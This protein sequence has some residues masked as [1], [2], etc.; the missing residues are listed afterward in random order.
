MDIQPAFSGQPTEHCDIEQEIRFS[1][2][3]YGGVSLAIYMNGIAQEFRHLVRAT[4]PD[5][6]ASGQLKNRN[7]ESTES[8]YR[9]LGQLLSQTE[10]RPH[11]PCA[12]E[13]VRTRFV[14]DT[15]SGTSAGGIN[16]LFLAKALVND[17]KIN[18]L[19]D[20]WVDAADILDLINDAD[21]VKNTPLD[22]PKPPKAL[23]N[24]QRLY[25]QALKALNEMDESGPKPA[26][27]SP[28]VDELDVFLTTTDLRGVPTALRLSDQ[29][30]YERRH[31]N[32]FHFSYRPE[33]DD[34]DDD[35]KDTNP[36]LAFAARCT[37]SFPIAF[38]PMSLC[39]TE[40]VLKQV[41]KN[42]W[43]AYG[44]KAER[45]KR[46]YRNYE[47]PVADT[48]ADPTASQDRRKAELGF[49]PFPQ[50]FF[51]DGG[52]LDNKPFGYAI[53]TLSLRKG[54]MAGARK[55]VYIEPSPEA[56]TSEV[57]GRQP[58]A[59][60]NAASALTLPLNDTIREDLQHVLARN[61]MI[62]RIQRFTNGMEEDL[63]TFQYLSLLP[64]DEWRK[65]SLPEMIKMMGSSYGGYHRLKVAMV[66]DDLAALLASAVGLDTGSDECVAIWYLLRAWR[67]QRYAPTPSGGKQSENEFLYNFD[68]LY[69]VRRL[70]LLASKID[71]LSRADSS[72]RKLAKQIHLE[73]V[74]PADRDI[75]GFRVELRAL[76][77]VVADV[78][79]TLAVARR[80]LWRREDNPFEAE[81]KA[82]GISSKT[83]G[84]I[85]SGE[86][87]QDRLTKAT[88]IVAKTGAQLDALGVSIAKRF[89]K[90]TAVARKKITDALDSQNLADGDVAVNARRLAAHY[91]YAFETYDVLT[92]PLLH[93]TDIGELIPVDVVRI[94]P[95]DARSLIDESSSERRKLAGTKL[96]HFGAFLDRSWRVND[97]TWGRLD[98]AERLVNVL[99]PG[100]AHQQMRDALIREAQEI[101][102]KESVE[103]DNGVHLAGLLSEAMSRTP[104][105]GHDEAA[106]R[107]LI[108]KA[109]T[110]DVRSRMQ[111]ALLACLHPAKWREYYATKYQVKSG[112]EPQR[113]L[114]A[115]SRSTSV[116]GELLK[117]I[118]RDESISGTPAAVVARS[119][120][121]L[122]AFAAA[123][124]PG[125]IWKRLTSHWIALVTIAALLLIVAGPLLQQDG[126]SRVGW[127][128]LA[129]LGVTQIAL[130]ALGSY[131]TGSRR[132]RRALISVMLFVVVVLATIG[133]WTS[134]GWVTTHSANLVAVAWSKSIDWV[135]HLIGR[136]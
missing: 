80:Q 47:D 113:T 35:F 115:I 101:I 79:D 65:K 1:L 32:V 121:V 26:R 122:G 3:M 38:E 25:Y 43:E 46:F 111:A 64:A 59:I 7:P 105:L 8:V 87:D 89:E 120:R 30:V 9:R 109:E 48:A 133:G 63:D 97:I 28:N 134:V 129:V 42:G 127:C 70:A 21:S 107:E 52:Y 92:L 34:K 12:G 94:S 135:R 76:R 86:N 103:A 58:D 72:A 95:L 84:A 39:A 117:A 51:G 106:L 27:P 75:E 16:G 73:D 44:A 98:A 136:P 36:F 54:R 108:E 57:D 20:L 93:A 62:E 69:P 116:I 66:V 124:V 78:D 61:R 91:Y 99:L 67:L 10:V 104:A 49:V 126:V 17:Q 15:I 24:G 130:I 118:S 55:L 13:P 11:A 110:P 125:S 56:V 60:T 2:V 6:T 53:D 77:K 19:R 4:A 82:L 88:A 50:R 96:L 41:Y 14:V 71:E 132:V 131:I 119:G 128:V 5:P 33:N 22:P 83:L 37:S 74:W 102:L 90:L 68:F 23:L 31:K 85:L 18:A 114:A 45:W 100:S 112:L 40:P 123:A 29:A 81:V